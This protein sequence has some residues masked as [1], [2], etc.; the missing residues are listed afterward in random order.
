MSLNNPQNPFTISLP[1]GGSQQNVSLDRGGAGYVQEYHG[2][3]YPG[4]FYQKAFSFDVTAVT[5]PVNAPTLA[6]VFTLYNPPTSG[7]NAELQSID[8][9]LLSATTVIDVLGLYWQ[10]P[11]LASLATLSTI[12]VWGTNWFGAGTASGNPGQVTPYSAF[13][14]SGQPVRTDIINSWNTT[15]VV[16]GT[17]ARKDYNGRKLLPPGHVWSLAMSTAAGH[18]S[19]TDLH[20]DWQEASIT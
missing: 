15:S 12:G 14:H 3:G 5:V 9:G 16:V 11:T 4:A 8:V 6:S 18:A 13:T 2:P 20:M 19:T 10:G 1:P 7:V 17:P